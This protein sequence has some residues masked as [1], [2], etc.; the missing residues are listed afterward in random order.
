[1]K[2]TLI[3]FL[4]LAFLALCIPVL[5]QEV[6]NGVP[7]PYKRTAQTDSFNAKHSDADAAATITSQPKHH[8]H[9]KHHKQNDTVNAYSNDVSKTNS[10]K[11]EAT[12]NNDN[13]IIW[14]IVSIITLIVVWKIFRSRYKRK[15]YKCKRW[16]A[17]RNISTECID[18]KPSTV[19]EKRKRMDAEGNIKETWEVDLPATEYT[20]RT[21]RR[22]KYCDNED[23]VTYTKTHKN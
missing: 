14:W 22:C 7:C 15:C 13:S 10:A 6:D 19:K 3:P 21:H 1:M 5:S 4:M 23:Y 20:Y 12:I 8:K 16:G 17:M 2:K 11:N 18:E 9:H